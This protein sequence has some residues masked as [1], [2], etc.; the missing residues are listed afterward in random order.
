[1][2]ALQNLI[3]RFPRNR[4][5]PDSYLVMLRIYRDHCNRQPHNPDLYPLAQ[6]ALRKFRADFPTDDRVIDQIRGDLSEALVKTGKFF[7]RTKKPGAA[8]VY[9]ETALRDYGETP[10]APFCRER[11]AALG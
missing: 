8:V 2:A 9:Y 4:Y 1:M 10:S 6:I 7:E 3:S 5:A 11:I